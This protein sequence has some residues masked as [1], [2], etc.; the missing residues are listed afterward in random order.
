MAKRISLTLQDIEFSE[1]QS[2][3]QS[4]GKSLTEWVRRTL[5]Q[6]LRKHSTQ[7]VE[8]K[9]NALRVAAKY[10]FPT[11]DIEDMLSQIEQGRCGRINR[12]PEK[13]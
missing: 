3:A 7:S 5:V 12:D 6:A 4:Q 13:M 11:A 1:F 9:L 8:R 10:S 2:L